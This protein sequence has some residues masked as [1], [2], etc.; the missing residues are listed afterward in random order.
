MR[1]WRGDSR[2]TGREVTAD[3]MTD[4]RDARFRAVYGR[5]RGILEPY[6]SRMYV[7]AS[8]APS[9]GLDLPPEA[10]RIPATWFGGVRLG[11]SYVSYYLMAVYV[12]PSLLHGG[13]RELDK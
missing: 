6:A 1:S 13:C 5:L 2:S 11:K 7:S 3:T 8:D 4:E 10:E 12:Q 9:Y